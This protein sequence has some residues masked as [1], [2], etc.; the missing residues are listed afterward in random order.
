[1][2]VGAYHS[3]FRFKGKEFCFPSLMPG[4]QELADSL[5]VVVVMVCVCACVCMCVCVRMLMWVAVEDGGGDDGGVCVCVCTCTSM[6][7]WVAVKSCGG[8][9]KSSHILF[10]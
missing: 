7:M 10:C 9:G 5:G 6:R 4:W 1:M 8:G 3:H 2:A